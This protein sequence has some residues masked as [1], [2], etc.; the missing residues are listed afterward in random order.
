MKENEFFEGELTFKDLEIGDMFFAEN[1][2]EKDI[3]YTKSGIT[4]AEIEDGTIISGFDP[5]E[6]VLF[7]GREE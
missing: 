1:E 4:V 3:L 5:D 2:E 6:I 7:A